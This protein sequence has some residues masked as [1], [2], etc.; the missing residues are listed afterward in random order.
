MFE[1]NAKFKYPNSYCIPWAFVCDGKWDCPEGADENRENFCQNNMRCA[2]MFRCHETYLCILWQNECD[3]HNECYLGDDEMLCELKDVLCPSNCQCILFAISCNAGDKPE[4]LQTYISIKFSGIAIKSLFK[5]MKDCQNVMY[6]QLSNSGLKSPC[7]LYY[8]KRLQILDFSRNIFET[9][10]QL[11]FTS[12]PNLEI[13]M[14]DQNVNTY[15]QT[16]SFI[17]IQKLYLLNISNNPLKFFLGDIYKC[18]HSMKVLSLRDNQ[19]LTID[20]K[21]FFNLK[22]DYIE[23]DDYRIFCLVDASYICNAKKPWFKS[24][25]NLLLDFKTEIC[26]ITM[27]SLI[28]TANALSIFMHKIKFNSAFSVTVISLNIKDTLCA[29]YFKIIWISH[30]Y[31]SDTF[32]VKE[33]I[34]RSGLMCFIAFGI[35]NWFTLLT[36]TLL[37]FLSLLRL[38]VAIKPL[39]ANFKDQLL[40][41]KW[42]AII[43]TVCFMM[44][45]AI[46]VTV[47]LTSNSLPFHFCFPFIDPTNS[48]KKIKE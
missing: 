17:D 13:L 39:E 29:I 16:F 15:L 21:A 6:L 20:P 30:F 22:V 24:C 23:T 4:H 27:S 40:I 28:I 47:K 48:I 12:L 18:P 38:M 41:T 2:G 35:V 44:S 3:G 11:C 31:L 9:I 8:P 5:Y 43:F 46:T 10:K 19:L 14:L 37:V 7:H 36:Q 26:F 1:C 32:A 42:L 45:T 25:T 34:W 33:E